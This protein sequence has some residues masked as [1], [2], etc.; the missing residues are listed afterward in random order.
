MKKVLPAACLSSFI[1]LSGQPSI[2]AVA[3][4]TASIE[5]DEVV[6]LTTAEKK[7]LLWE[8]AVE[9]GIPPEI[10][11][12]IAQKETDMTQ[13]NEDG[14]PYISED[15]GIGMMQ[16]TL[17][18]E[19]QLTSDID[20]ERLKTDLRYNIEVG[21]SI[22]KEKWEWDFLPIINDH[23]PTV[24]ENWY[25]AVMAYN[26]LS[27]RNDPNFEENEP[28]QEKVFQSIRENSLLDIKDIPKVDIT[29]ADPDKPELMTFSVASYDWPE[30]A[31]Q[32]TQLLTTGDQVYTL[33][34]AASYSYIRHDVDGEHAGNL[35][36][37]TPLEIVSGP[38]ESDNDANHLVYYEVKGNGVDAYISSSNLQQGNVSV[39]PDIEDREVA[40]AVT[41]LQLKGMISGHVDGTFKPDDTLL[42]RH[43]ASI[44]VKALDLKLPEGYKMKATDM[45]QGELGYD[46]MVIAEA[47]GIMGV[48][49][50]LRP[51]EYL[52]RSQI[53]SILARTYTDTYEAATTN[54]AFIDMDDTYWNYEDINLLANN[55][56]TDDQAF[57]PE[58][59]V[60]R[61][62]FSLFLKRT[63][64]LE[65]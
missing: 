11:K 3:E 59:D 39:F 26:G 54:V 24:I 29:Y 21:A 44:L 60:T 19:Q 33:N 1:L 57:R 15:G 27:K 43:A 51:N 22:L 18:E 41:Y 8:V 61:A 49:G 25:F 5:K 38:F 14:T 50:K 28:Y 47:H 40:A 10:L 62:E 20:V 48:G 31:T 46:E 30:L 16:I 36:H 9:Y 45:E 2:Q 56:I 64:T 53:S 17:T 65:K 34:N 55:G 58:D 37:Y 23:D 13:F 42:R 35:P 6:Q 12:A 32:S 7:Q 4:T 63:L 52:T